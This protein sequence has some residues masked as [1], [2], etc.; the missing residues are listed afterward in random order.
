MT[1]F[2][3]LP[4]LLVNI[5]DHMGRTPLHEACCRGYFRMIHFLLVE[6]VDYNVNFN[7]NLSDHLGN[8]PLHYIIDGW[9]ETTEDLECLNTLTYLLSKNPFLIFHR[10][11]Q[12]ENL[13]D[14]AQR[15]A[16][17]E[18][19]LD[20]ELV[21]EFWKLLFDHIENSMIN[22]RNHIYQYFLNNKPQQ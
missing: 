20:N 8:T 13:L 6:S 12:N 22:A 11:N 17:E 9:F 1:K 19:T 14:Y 10:N 21:Q 5:K 2:L 18:G 16:Q 7:V 4:N 3:R 15:R